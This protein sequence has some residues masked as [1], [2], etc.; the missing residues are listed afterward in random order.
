[1]TS[2]KDDLVDLM[3]DPLWSKL[4]QNI[5]LLEDFIVQEKEKNK[6]IKD[7][8][9]TKGDFLL[10]GHCHQKSIFTTQSIHKIFK[11]KEG[12]RCN[13]IE[14]SCCGMAGSFGYE[15]K[16]YEL[17]VKM[18]NLKLIPAIQESGE[19]VKIIAQGF[20]CRHQ[21]KDLAHRDAYHWIEVI[22]L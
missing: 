4:S 8:P 16:H 3:D 12:V 6:I 2:L 11:N 9:L 13:E 7:I 10:H 17:S 1:A 20:S 18:A 21:I 22:D 15:K 14:S 5:Y 19:D